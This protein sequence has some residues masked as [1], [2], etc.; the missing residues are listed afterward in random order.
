[1]VSFGVRLKVWGDYASF[2]RPEMK[3]ERVSYDVM[4]PS[5]ARGILE[6]IYWKPQMRWVVDRIHVLAPI[7]FTTIRRNEVSAKIPAGTVKSA[8]KKLK[9]HLGA[10]IQAQRQQR[11]AM[12]LKNVVYGIEAHVEVRDP[13]EKD[14]TVLDNPEAKH[15]DTFKRRAA[16]GKCFQR[17][18]F[19]CREF[20]VSFELVDEF[21]QPPAEFLGEQPREL[22]FMLHDFE[23]IEDPKG[24]II[25]S[26]RGTRR[27]AVP[28][29]F[30]ASIVNGVVEVPR[31]S[32]TVA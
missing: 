29:F 2:N 1:M 22:G 17:P 15:L 10:D 32:E 28:H 30:R 20:P 23:F 12:V 25:E 7:H 31:L 19:G 9:G 18:Y 3:V 8:A 11:S 24:K 5:A 14:E 21:E 6:A 4:T 26:N 16:G 27:R 13:T